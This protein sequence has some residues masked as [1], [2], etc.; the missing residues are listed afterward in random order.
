MHEQ[1]VLRKLVEQHVMACA[2]M[3]VYE[4]ANTPAIEQAGFYDDLMNLCVSDTPDTTEA[5]QAVKEAEEAVEDRKSTIEDRLDELRDLVEPHCDWGIFAEI[6][7][8]DHELGHLKTGEHPL[9]VALAEAREKLEDLQSDGEREILEHWIVDEGFGERL[10][11]HGEKVVELFG[12]TIWGRTCSGQAI[13]LDG[14]IH[15]I[16]KEMEI[17]PG[18]K[19][20]W[21]D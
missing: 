12:L 7:L 14:V 1:N 9:G 11:E 3:M 20:E 15:E 6:E 21:K 16:A 4:L 8:L 2:S 10:R 13:L 18:Q 19:Y 17:L 5:E